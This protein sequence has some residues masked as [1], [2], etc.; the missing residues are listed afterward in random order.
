LEL[1]QSLRL[2][3]REQSFRPS[4]LEEAEEAFATNSLMGIAF[5][6]NWSKTHRVTARLQHAFRAIVQREVENS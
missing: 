3:V 5:I 2:K 1:A 4:R 6:T